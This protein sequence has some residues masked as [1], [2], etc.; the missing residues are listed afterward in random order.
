MSAVHPGGRSSSALALTLALAPALAC[1]DPVDP[2][3]R[4]ALQETARTQGDAVGRE[5][6]GSYVLAGTR[7]D[8]D[9]PPL[10]DLEGTLFQGVDLCGAL[11]V[12]TGGLKIDLYHEDGLLAADLAGL[13]ALFGGV[14][15]DG[16]FAVA[17]VFDAA[18]L[19]GPGDLHARIEGTIVESRIEATLT[20]RLISEGDLVSVDCRATSTLNG[21]RIGL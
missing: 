21:A 12:S 7:E 20:N 4:A 18:S 10:A 15:A 14:W 1:D 11:G 3:D 16:A 2:L 13:I 6:G 5:L 19:L 17:G 8:C 9:C